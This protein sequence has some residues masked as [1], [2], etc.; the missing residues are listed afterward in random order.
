MG[1][2]C[3]EELLQDSQFQVNIIYCEPAHACALRTLVTA[4]RTVS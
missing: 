3:E 1:D 2:E 4:A